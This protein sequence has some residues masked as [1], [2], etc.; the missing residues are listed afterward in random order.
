MVMA[1][2]MRVAAVLTGSALLLGGVAVAPSA[3]A[4]GGYGEAA[5]PTVTIPAGQTNPDRR[6]VPAPGVVVVPQSVADRTAPT[7]E[8]SSNTR[9]AATRNATDIEVG[10][11][12]QASVALPGASRTWRVRLETPSGDG[13]DF[14][15]LRSDRQGDLTTPAIRYTR[16]GTY[17]WV[18]TSGSVTRF[19]ALRAS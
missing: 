10:T 2:A 18:F 14:G 4:C 7:D 16:T 17:T 6:A 15:T 13:A 8:T 3:A 19:L 1:M 5:C 9:R 12:V 11:V